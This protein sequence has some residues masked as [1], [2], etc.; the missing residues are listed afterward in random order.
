M[1]QP[2]LHKTRTRNLLHSGSL[3]AAGAILIAVALPSLPGQKFLPE[4]FL[5]P[6]C[7]N[8]GAGQESK[9]V[10]YRP[11]HLGLGAQEEGLVGGYPRH[12]PLRFPLA[13]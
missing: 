13:L 12:H 10:A 11:H 9:G 5:C 7:C 8:F 2:A 6:S 1:P 3:L 4:S